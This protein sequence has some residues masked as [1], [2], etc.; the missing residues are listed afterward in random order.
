MPETLAGVWSKGPNTRLVSN[1][2]LTAVVG[3]REQVD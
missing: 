3:A 1:P 2:F